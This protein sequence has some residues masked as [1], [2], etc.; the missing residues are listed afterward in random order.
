LQKPKRYEEVAQMKKI[1]KQTGF[2]LGVA[3]LC[4]IV[5]LG[6]K[7]YYGRQV[8]T[9]EVI[10]EVE[11]VVEKE[12]EISGE[13]IRAGMANIGKLS[14]AEYNFTHV[15]R[16]DSSREIRGFKI[17][18]TKTTFIYSYDGSIMA[19]ID[20]TRIQIDKDDVKKEITVTLP[21]VEIISSEVDQDSFK[22]Y[23]ERNNIF[24]PISVTDVMDSFADLK[25]A[26][27]KKAVEGG[28][29]NKAKANAVTLVD[30]FM[31]GS[32]N[33]KDYDIEVVFVTDTN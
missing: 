15:E 5:F 30:H 12:V 4:C 9:V 3:L 13:T 27:E 22:L 17:P 11:T 18:L 32:Y 8:K 26:E 20:F 29:L 7:Y 25:T 14:T 1:F 23:D 10:R 31:H 21:E 19:G 24:N 16:V 6:T 2:V 28:L 33:V